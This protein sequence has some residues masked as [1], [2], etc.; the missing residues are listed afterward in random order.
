MSFPSKRK[1]GAMRIS[2]MPAGLSTWKKQDFRSRLLI[3]YL[4][5]MFQLALIWMPCLC[6]TKYLNIVETKKIHV[7][8][9]C[10][11]ELYNT[12]S[13]LCQNLFSLTIS[14]SLSPLWAA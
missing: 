6:F 2:T 7:H 14:V 5:L 11:E 3:L 13:A 10:D 1:Q 8:Y 9:S 4:Y 12:A